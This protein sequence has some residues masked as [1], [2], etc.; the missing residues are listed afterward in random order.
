MIIDYT[1]NGLTGFNPEEFPEAQDFVVEF[2]SSEF[3][4]NLTFRVQSLAI[5]MEWGWL[6][7][8][9]AEILSWTV[10][11]APRGTLQ[12]PYHD[13]DQGWNVMIWEMEDHV[14]VAEGEG[15]WDED[16]DSN[17]YTM[18]FKVPCALYDRAWGEALKRLQVG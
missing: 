4:L 5:I 3:G 6:K 11:N 18:W 10:G 8:T 12:E 1:P 2:T 13:S 9:D 14:Y 17:T 16:R 7:A 15:E